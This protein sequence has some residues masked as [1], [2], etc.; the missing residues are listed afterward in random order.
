MA[1]A[2]RVLP[3][4]PILLVAM[5]IQNCGDHGGTSDGLQ[6]CAPPNGD[7]CGDECTAKA[8]DPN[9]CGECGNVC[10]SNI[11]VAGACVL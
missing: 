4:I 11:C 9:N 7:E 10:S 3:L 6:V 2:G 1:A 8:S 5:V